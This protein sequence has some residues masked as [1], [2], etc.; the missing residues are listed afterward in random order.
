MI[1]QGKIADDSV[2]EDEERGSDEAEEEGSDSKSELVKD[3]GIEKERSHINTVIFVAV[4]GVNVAKD[5]WV[6]VLMTETG[7]QGNL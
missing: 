6:A 4:G 7:I 2:E 1:K 3:E 5:E